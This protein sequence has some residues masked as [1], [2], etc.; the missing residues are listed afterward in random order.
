MVQYSI[1]VICFQG[2][3]LLAYYAFLRRETF[4]TYNR[5]Y[6]LGTAALSL[7]LPFIKID[8]LGSMVTNQEF[9]F[10]TPYGLSGIT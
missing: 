10:Q 9:F 1:Q 4:F 2:L 3:F 7:L 5:M 6:L 8:I